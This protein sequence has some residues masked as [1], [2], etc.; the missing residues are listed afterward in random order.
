MSNVG[1]M[2]QEMP[3]PAANIHLGTHG[4]AL[5]VF[6]AEGKGTSKVEIDKKKNCKFP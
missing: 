4:Q 5:N 6:R 2:I 1:I 3:I